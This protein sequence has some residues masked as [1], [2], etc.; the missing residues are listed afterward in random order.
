MNFKTGLNV[1][2]NVMKKIIIESY[3]NKKIP[4]V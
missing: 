3:K 4:I 1:N 2:W